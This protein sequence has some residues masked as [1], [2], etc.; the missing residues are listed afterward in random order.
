VLCSVFCSVSGISLLDQR[1]YIAEDAA[2]VQTNEEAEV[3]NLTDEN[4]AGGKSTGN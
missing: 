4:G 1:H 3:A 2:S